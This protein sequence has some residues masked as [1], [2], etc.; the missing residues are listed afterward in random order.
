M[1]ASF[2]AG[3]GFCFGTGSSLAGRWESE[4]IHFPFGT[5][6]WRRVDVQRNV[7]QYAGVVL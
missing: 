5:V 7:I 6:L 4:V 2:P 3:L 1:K